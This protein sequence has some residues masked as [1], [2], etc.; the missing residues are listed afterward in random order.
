M[1]RHPPEPRRWALASPRRL[2]GRG[3][4]Q[5]YRAGAASSPRSVFGS[6]F[7]TRAGRLASGLTQYVPQTVRDRRRAAAKTNSQSH[8]SGLEEGQP[9]GVEQPAFAPSS[10]FA[11]QAHADSPPPPPATWDADQEQAAQEA[12]EMELADY[13]IYGV[14]RKFASAARAMAYYDCRLCLDELDTLPVQHKRSAS[15][16]AMLGKAHYE[17]GQY[18]EVS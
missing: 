2:R 16:M 7:R 1:R 13:H 5:D 8:D 6:A 3:G 18:R 14:M 17:L 11:Q 15:V 10:P 12:Y 4:V 9:G